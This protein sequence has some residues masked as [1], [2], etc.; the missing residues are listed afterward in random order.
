M[1]K[2][3]VIEF[4][5]TVGDGGAE[6]L[7]K[8]YALLMDKD[9]FEVTVV[10]VH[11]VDDSANWQR[12]RENGIRVIAL[13]SRDDILKKI[14]RTVFKP[15]DVE[16][17]PEEAAPGSTVPEQRSAVR[18]VSAY[19]R[20]RF[21]AKKLLRIVRQT[22]AAVIHAHL[23]VLEILQAARKSLKGVRLFHTCHNVPQIVYVDGEDTAAQK[24]I[25]ENGMQLI[26]LHSDMTR[27]LNEMFRVDNTATIRNG[28]DM[29][30][31]MEPGIHRQTKREEI[32][33][34]KDAFVVG[35][36]GRFSE[37]KNQMY[38]V[39]V[40]RSIARRR[41][42]AFLLM[43]GSGDSAAAEAKLRE[44]G[45][46]DRYRILSHRKDI[47]ELLAVMDVFV[48]P[49]I[50]EGLSVSLVEAQAAGLR[51]IVSDRCST[52]GLCTETCI[53]MPLGDPEKWAD[54]ALDP[55]VKQ[56]NSGNLLDYDMNRE[57]RRLEK[58]Y[59]GHPDA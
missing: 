19:F 52:E 20:N 33:L 58:L 1:S 4:I 34:P 32:G 29:P 42:D 9:R 5:T 3:N 31:F 8:D 40:F 18:K 35:H 57:I 16:L 55:S 47:N 24:L 21:F 10:V 48:F 59:L 22:D 37:Q 38:L 17:I 2:V 46:Q 23:D 50:F 26:A 51:C 44:Y 53:S 39:E 41:A 27:E 49:S 28:I 56:E 6:T 30:R 7:V 25:R 12:L 54:A 45:L 36:V 14:W 43:V 11:D 15:S 13:S